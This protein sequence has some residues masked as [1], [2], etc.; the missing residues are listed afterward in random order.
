MQNSF[1][2]KLYLKN[3]TSEQLIEIMQYVYAFQAK[4]QYNKI[5]KMLDEIN[6]HRMDSVII[7]SLLRCNFPIRQK[8]LHWN[9]FLARAQIILKDTDEEKILLDLLQKE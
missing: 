1:Y 7:L 5:D 2:L 9:R 4:M 3:Q 8:L 6:I